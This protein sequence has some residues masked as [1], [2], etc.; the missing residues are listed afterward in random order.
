[1]NV[2]TRLLDASVAASTRPQ[3]QATGS[4]APACQQEQLRLVKIGG[5]G[6]ISAGRHTVDREHLEV[7]ERG[8]QL[9]LARR[10]AGRPEIGRPFVALGVAQHRALVEDP[11]GGVEGLAGFEPAGG[12]E[13]RERRD[14][15]GGA[16]SQRPSD[17]GEH[18]GLL[19]PAEEAEPALAEAE[20]RVEARVVGEV[21]D[22]AGDEAGR[23][24]LLRRGGAGERHELRGGVD[25]GD[26]EAPRGEREGVAARP[27]ADV[28]D[29]LARREAQGLA[30]E[31]DLLVG[32]TGEGH[33][34]AGAGGP[35]GGAEEG[36]DLV[37]PEPGRGGRP[38][39]HFASAHVGPNPTSTTSGTESSVTDSMVSRTSGSTASRSSSG[40]SKT[41]SSWTVRSIR[42]RYPPS[43]STR[44]TSI[45]ASL[46]MSAAEP[47]TGAFW[48]IRSPIWRMRKLSDD[49]STIWRRRP[50]SVVV[51]PRSFASRTVWDMN[52]PTWGKPS[53]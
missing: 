35:V 3:A 52:A 8:E 19:A 9:E 40:T 2:T 30:Q 44:S 27:A 10:E 34:P 23:E 38:G 53:K 50:N 16:G 45:I 22:V 32:P 28:E 39:G 12:E 11:G 43:V 1:M 13:Q 15:E 51:Y 42:V 5:R 7:G 37:E 41:S 29:L 17:A 48:A 6:A 47:C 24:A 33:D 4:R 36:R 20:D 14:G 46:K 26:R 18:R 21:P 49:S 31:V 25:P